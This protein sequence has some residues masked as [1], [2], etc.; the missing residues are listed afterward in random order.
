MPTGADPA[1]MMKPASVI[2]PRGHGFPRGAATKPDHAFTLVARDGK[3]A[4]VTEA[5]GMLDR[6][7]NA[8]ECTHRMCLH[9]RPG[10][11]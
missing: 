11:S 7:E 3:Q 9:Q 10:D 8:E 5:W 1:A 4:P 6:E 2:D